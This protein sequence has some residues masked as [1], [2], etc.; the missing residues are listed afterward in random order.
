VIEWS[1]TLVMGSLKHPGLTNI[2]VQ[3]GMNGREDELTNISVLSSEY[4]ANWIYKQIDSTYVGCW[5]TNLPT[6]QFEIL[7][8]RWKQTYKQISSNSKQ[9]IDTDADTDELT[10]GQF[11]ETDNRGIDEFTTDQFMNAGKKGY[12]WTYYRSVH[13]CMYSLN[14]IY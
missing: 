1:N 2:L 6:D 13:E 5:K 3:W 10:I 9:I 12:M 8:N 4:N 11:I 14:W 7:R